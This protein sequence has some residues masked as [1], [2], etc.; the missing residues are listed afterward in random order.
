M[1]S[2]KFYYLITTWSH[3]SVGKDAWIIKE[4]LTTAQS[5][6]ER[7]KADSTKHSWQLDPRK[8]K[9]GYEGLD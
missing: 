4:W 5:Q 2:S 7:K 1:A 3:K 8:V 9:L 6:A